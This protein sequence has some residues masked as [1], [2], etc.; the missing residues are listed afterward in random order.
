MKNVRGRTTYADAVFPLALLHFGHWENM[1]WNFQVQFVLATLVGGILLTVVAQSRKPLTLK[2]VLL[3]GMSLVLA[4]LCGAGALLLAP[5]LGAWFILWGVRSWSV[6]QAGKGK[7]LLLVLFGLAGLVLFGLYMYDFHEPPGHP[8]AP[9]LRAAVKVSLEALAV[10][11]GPAAKTLWP[12]LGVGFAALLLASA[13]VVVVAWWRRPEE[14]LRALGL[15]CFVVGV[16][17]LVFGIGWGRSGYH[18]DIGFT[19]RYGTLTVLAPC[20]LYFIWEIC[21][22]TSLRQLVPM[23]LH[24]LLCALLIPNC[25]V[26]L[27]R[28]KGLHDSYEAFRRDLRAGAPACVLAQ[29]HPCLYPYRQE[30]AEKMEMMHRAGMGSFKKMADPPAVRAVSVPVVPVGLYQMTWKDGT[31]QGAGAGAHVLLAL[32]EPRFVF[33]I[34]LSYAY[35]GA[36]DA[37][38]SFRAWWKQNGHNDYRE[39]ERNAG[40]PLD[41]KPGEHTVDVY[42]N[43]TI[44]QFRVDPDSKPCTFTLSQIQLLVPCSEASGHAASAPRMAVVPQ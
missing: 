15:M 29:N 33:G 20:C 19:D 25:Q 37:P 39:G 44:D 3:G 7:A 18:Q 6:P 13:A 17:G 42:V 30:L 4:P 1:L 24:T 34:R 23:A 22:P 36:G 41:A 31:G 8:N 21:V 5:L 27:V 43:D 28:G 14:R 40:F 38:A 12:Y 26:G 2:G 32:P 11:C 10:S 16:G 35:A 9:S